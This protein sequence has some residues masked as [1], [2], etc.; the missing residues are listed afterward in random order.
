M[1]LRTKLGLIWGGAEES[2]DKAQDGP[3]N[4]RTKEPKIKNQEIP[5]HPAEAGGMGRAEKDKNEIS[6]DDLERG[7][8]ID[9]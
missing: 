6:K 4:E 3:K 1:I 2:F 8:E 9:L 5:K 7:G